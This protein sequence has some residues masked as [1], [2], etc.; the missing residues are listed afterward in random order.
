MLFLTIPTANAHPELLENI[1]AESAIPRERIVLI[2]TRPNLDL[3]N[4][5][6]V[7]EDLGQPNIQRWW[8]R[9]IEESIKRGATAVAVLNDDLVINGDTLHTLHSELIRAKATIASP[10]RADWGPGLYKD[11]NIFPYT[12]VIWGCLW[13]IDA[14]SQLRPDPKYVWWYGDSDLDIRARRD[15]SGI[16]T[17]DVYYEHFFAGEGTKK[18]EALSAQTNLDAE[19]FE[20]NYKEFLRSSRSTPSRKLFIQAQQFSARINAESSYREDF[21]HYVCKSGDPK[22]DRVVLVEP[23]THLH[24]SIRELWCQWSNVL[25]SEKC[26][27]SDEKSRGGTHVSMFRLGD[28]AYH[29]RLSIFALDVQRFGPHLDVEKVQIPAITFSNLIQEVSPGAELNIL[30]FDS[31]VNSLLDISCTKSQA[32]EIIVITS[33]LEDKSLG[34]EAKGLALHFVGRPWGEARTCAAFSYQRRSPIRTL[35]TV[36]GHFASSLVDTRKQFITR[37][38]LTEFFKSKVGKGITR[39]DVLDSNHGLPISAISRHQVDVI[40]SQASGATNEPDSNDFEWQVPVDT[41]SQIQELAQKC[42]TTHGVWPLSMSIPTHLAVNPHPSEL[43][44]PL[45][46]GY[47]YSFHSEAEYL[48]K[49][50]DAYFALTHRKAGWDCFR[51]V[52]IMASGSVPLMPDSDQIPEFAMVHYPKQAFAKI[53]QKVQTIGGRP[54]GTLRAELR[55]FFLSHLTTKTMADYILAAANILADASV[56][57]LDENLP[58]NPEYMSTLTAIGLK[59]SLGSNCVLHFPGEFLYSDSLS[60]TH[61]FYGRG[62]GY[63]KQLDPS[64]R[65]DWELAP[66]HSFEVEEIDFAQYDFVVIGS[67]SRNMRL[68]QKVLEKFPAAKTVLIHGEDTPPIIAAA[69]FLRST[70]AHVFIRSIY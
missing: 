10:T 35:W 31:R 21:F 58:S 32:V 4:G 7:I 8:N 16:V 65:S 66:R 55:E 22:R 12:P 29:S 40:A 37:N 52:E 20:S 62:F 44:S 47:P 53:S 57:F 42:F 38:H 39:S 48:A 51:H 54:N 15:H 34:K 18:S 9:G 3:P 2:A 56:L 45:I 17:A 69:H 49:Y 33:G 70:K 11:S 24:Q 64:L 6:T 5:C 25:I 68:T 43:V 28:P 61:S 1:I 27:V 26:L 50:A 41:D 23:D 30:A 19:T 60:E 14:T 67:V 36:V 63:V 46:P 13:L 59:E